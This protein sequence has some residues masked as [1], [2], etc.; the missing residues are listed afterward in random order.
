[1]T[2]HEFVNLVNNKGEHKKVLLDTLVYNLRYET[3][4]P[5]NG[6]WIY[7]W[8][9]GG[10]STIDDSHFRRLHRQYEE[11]LRMAMKKRV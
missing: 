7:E 9:E 1:M 11:N 4:G 3:N 8:P 10:F 2:D 6:L 5:F